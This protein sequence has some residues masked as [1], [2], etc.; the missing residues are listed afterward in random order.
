MIGVLTSICL[1]ISIKPA[2]WVGLTTQEVILLFMTMIFVL[3]R[4]ATKLLFVAG[5]TPMFLSVR[6]R[7]PRFPASGRNLPLDR[8]RARVVGSGENYAAHRGQEN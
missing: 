4:F 8:G 6:S 1:R 2:P 7:E 5:I 3:S